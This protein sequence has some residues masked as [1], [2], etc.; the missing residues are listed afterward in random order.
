MFVQDSYLHPPS[1]GLATQQMNMLDDQIIYYWP[2][3]FYD[4]R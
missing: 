4:A 1:E 2:K 3:G